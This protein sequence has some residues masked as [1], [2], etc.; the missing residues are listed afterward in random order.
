MFGLFKSV[1]NLMALKN[2]INAKLL[3][4]K[5]SNEKKQEIKQSAI[6]LYRSGGRNHLYNSI[7]PE[8]Q[9]YANEEIN[10]CERNRDFQFYSML[11]YAFESLGYQPELPGEEW[12]IIKN[13][14][15]LHI[16]E[17]DVSVAQDW[18]RD[19]HGIAIQMKM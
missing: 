3:F 14:F 13:P 17:Y 5:C 11:C 2:A 18:F 16:K 6:A 9:Q 15:I 4:K 8:H 12:Q 1:K 7:K 10:E 19:K